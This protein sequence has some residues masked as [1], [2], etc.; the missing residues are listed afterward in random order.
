MK[1]IKKFSFKSRNSKKKIRRI[2]EVF[3]E[4]QIAERVIQHL[5]QKMSIND[6]AVR[7]QEHTN[8][9]E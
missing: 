6:Y 7:F 5:I 4:K 2:F 1:M 8:L 3:N 9:I